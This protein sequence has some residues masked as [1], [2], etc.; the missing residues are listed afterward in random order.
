MENKITMNIESVE[1]TALRSAKELTEIAN[2]LDGIIILAPLRDSNEI[3][4]E[5]SGLFTKLEIAMYTYA[6]EDETFRQLVLNTAERVKMSPKSCKK[7][8]K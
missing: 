2:Q 4:C 3:N 1:E 5:C 8:M 6:C 7:G